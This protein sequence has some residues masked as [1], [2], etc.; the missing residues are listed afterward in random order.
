MNNLSYYG[1]NKNLFKKDIEVKDLYKSESYK[2]GIERLEYI[3]EVKGIGLITG[4]TGVGKTTLIRGYINTLNKEKYNIIYISLTNSKK[5]EFLS[6][7]CNELRL[8]LGECYISNIKRK[9]QEEIINQKKN[10]GKETIIIID[11]AEKLNKEILKDFDFLYEFEYDSEDYTSIILCGGEEIKEELKKSIYE[12][13]K[14]RLIFIYKLDGLTKEESKEY[15][16]T[17]LKISGQTKMIYEKNAVYALHNA[18]HGI[19]R[20][21]NTL[22]NLSMIIGYQSK[23]EV[24][25]EEIIRIAVEESK[26]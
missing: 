3:K 21:L 23:K 16:E 11:N 9:I 14:Q 6:I 8:S 2:E 22:I 15:I 19:I 7:I 18:S 20:K 17:R 5:F 10:Y 12:S 25:D 13:L 4:V 26:I 1:L 24:I